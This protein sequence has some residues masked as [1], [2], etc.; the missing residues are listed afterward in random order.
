MIVRIV[1]E[2]L[3][4]EINRWYFTFL[5]P[6]PSD[7]FQFFGHVDAFGMADNGTWVFLYPRRD[8]FTIRVCQSDYA[9]DDLFSIALHEGHVLR[10]DH[11]GVFRL[12]PIGIYSCA[13]VCGHF[14]GIRAFTPWGLKRKLLRNGAVEINEIRKSKFGRGSSERAPSA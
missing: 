1:R 2:E 7:P 13:R 4:A 12:P 11:P 5:P 3:P 10:Y 8:S 9:I 6:K 14:V